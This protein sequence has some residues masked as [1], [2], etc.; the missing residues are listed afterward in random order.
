[1]SA[2]HSPRWW[3]PE[4]IRRVLQFTDLIEPVSLAFQKASAGEI[5]SGLIVM[6]PG[7]RAEHGDVYVKTGCQPGGPIHIVKVSPWF[8]ANAAADRPQGGF[9]AVLD[10]RTGYLLGLLD[11]QHY[12]SDVRTA[13]AGALAARVLAPRQ[14]ESATV[15]GAGTQAQ[16]Q[17]LA[18]FGERPFRVLRL[19]ARDQSKA[20]RLAK[21]LEPLL[22]GVAIEVEPDLQA[23]VRAADVLVTT[24]AAREPLVQADWLRPGM[25]IT[26]VG[27][28]DP[29]KAELDG[30]V[31][32]AGSVF[33]DS[34]EAASHNGD[35]HRAVRCQQ[36]TL[37]ELAG[38]LGHVLAGRLP[39][40]T[41]KAQITIAKFVGIGAQDLATAEVCVR[42]LQ[43]TAS[44]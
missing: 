37:E 31:L 36:Y 27:A 44:S 28:D 3:G 2:W 14:V 20:A 6:H 4:E 11:D 23:A 29:T 19:W 32:R 12:L 38:E 10:S 15:L 25:H 39:G 33:V 16:L 7:V 22:H 42:R 40:R 26:A 21:R 35:V 1:M 5:T 24:T 43:G 34:I 30:A 9:V 13:A 17:A 41:S 8:A 18:L